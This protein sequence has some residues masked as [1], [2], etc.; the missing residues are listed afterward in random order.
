M[1]PW[2]LEIA[3]RCFDCFSVDSAKKLPR[4]K[5]KTRNK[6]HRGRKRQLNYIPEEAGSSSYTDCNDEEILHDYI[7]NITGNLECSD[8]DFTFSKG[9]F[10]VKREFLSPLGFPNQIHP[11]VDETDSFSESFLLTHS[12]KKRRKFS[13]KHHMEIIDS[14]VNESGGPSFSQDGRNQ[15]DQVVK[16]QHTK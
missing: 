12:R 15:L 4:K 5:R 6:K 11:E 2:F 9:A 8:S 13:K 10:L 14:K 1:V 16:Q 7:E 3:G